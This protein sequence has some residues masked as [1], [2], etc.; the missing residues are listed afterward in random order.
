MGSIHFLRSSNVRTNS[1]KFLRFTAFSSAR[2]AIHM[3]LVSQQIDPSSLSDCRQLAYCFSINLYQDLLIQLFFQR[4]S[5]LGC[6]TVEN[7]R[8]L[9]D[10]YSQQTTFTIIVFLVEQIWQMKTI[11]LTLLIFKP[12]FKLYLHYYFQ[13]YLFVFFFVCINFFFF[14]IK[15]VF[16]LK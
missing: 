3:T 1:K 2:I 15:P 11:T 4:K 7:Y 5:T 16:H 6:Q 12:I 9:H 8:S 10:H 13:K 14:Y